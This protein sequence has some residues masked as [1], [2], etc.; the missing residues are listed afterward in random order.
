MF[1]LKRD[2]R[3][4]FPKEYEKKFLRSRD[5]K[6]ILLAVAS[7]LI[8]GVSIQYLFNHYPMQPHVRMSQKLMLRFAER[9]LN[10]MSEDEQASGSSYY[11]VSLQEDRTSSG[12]QMVTSSI[13]QK[14]LTSFHLQPLILRLEN[15]TA[16]KL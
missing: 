13:L 2:N 7:L 4:K 16:W 10:D 5:W 14:S 3:D 6:F 8:H 15:R 12:Q 1:R 11:S 9:Y